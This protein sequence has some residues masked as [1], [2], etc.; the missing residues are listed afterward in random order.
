MYAREAFF[1][2]FCCPSAF[3]TTCLSNHTPTLTNRLPTALHMHAFVSLQM[4]ACKQASTCLKWMNAAS[5]SVTSWL[6]A[7]CL[8]EN[9]KNT[10]L[11]VPFS[12]SFCCLC[13]REK[14]KKKKKKNKEKKKNFICH[15][16][17]RNVHRFSF[18]PL[19]MTS[20]L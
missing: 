11:N 3:Y 18:I 19:T 17:W 16:T 10:L 4:H 20:I 8:I 9:K 14:K 6:Q 13:V 2:F 15:L 1:F 7:C 5:Q 12:S